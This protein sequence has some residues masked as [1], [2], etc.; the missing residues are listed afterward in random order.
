MRF[1]TGWRSAPEPGARDE[2]IRD[3]DEPGRDET[4]LRNLLAKPAGRRLLSQL[5]RE[6]EA[7]LLAQRRETQR[8][9][10][11]LKGELVIVGPAKAREIDEARAR[12]VELQEELRDAE[13]A[14]RRMHGESLSVTAALEQRIGRLEQS[15]IKTASPAIDAVEQQLIEWFDV[16]SSALM[17]TETVEQRTGKRNYATNADSIEARGA[18]IR[19]ARQALAALRLEALDGAEL[20]ARLDA[21]VAGIPA[22]DGVAAFEIAVPSIA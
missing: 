8:Q 22:I 20:Q 15:L 18:A 13:A 19:A 4:A 9:A 3:V 7:E 12:V 1:P 2:A 16:L 14:V 21:L 11:A 17:T 5:E 6:D 10:V